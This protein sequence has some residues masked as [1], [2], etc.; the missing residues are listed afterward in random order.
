HFR[1]AN[2]AHPMARFFET[3]FVLQQ[4][5]YSSIYPIGQGLAMAVGWTLFGS[6]WSGVVLS[7]AAFCA[8]CYWMLRGWTTPGWALTGGILAVMAFGPLGQWMNSY[9]GGAL[10]AAAGCLVFGALPRM[11]ESYRRRDALLLGTGLAIHLLTR[12][13]ESVFLIAGVLL[14]F[15]P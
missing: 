1:L 12:P 11:R 15:R 4:P 5:T 7:T 10:A 2:P 13:Y 14:Y 9:W 8:L 6:P 3:I